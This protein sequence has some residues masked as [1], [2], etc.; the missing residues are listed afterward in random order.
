MIST[1]IFDDAKVFVLF[2]THNAFSIEVHNVKCKVHNKEGCELCTMH[3]AIPVITAL[4]TRINNIFV[5]FNTRKIPIL[6]AIFDYRNLMFWFPVLCWM[7]RKKIEKYSAEEVIISS[8]AAVKNV[9]STRRPVA[10]IDQTG[11]S[12]VDKAVKSNRK[13]PVANLYLHSPMQY[14]RE[15]YEENVSKLSF[16]I[17]QLYQFATTYLRPRD[18]KERHYDVVLCNSNYT[19]KLAKQLY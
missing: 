18:K 16:P 14:I 13:R 4:P 19:A 2:S 8:F 3:Y 10:K 15:N 12:Q 11:M 6:S 7:L 17:K 9:V 1:R 5:Y